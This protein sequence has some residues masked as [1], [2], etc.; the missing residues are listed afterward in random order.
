MLHVN[1]NML[2]VDIIYLACKGH[3]MPSC[4]CS[5]HCTGETHKK[6]KAGEEI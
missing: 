5:Q 4:V 2:H 6:E 1:I 3:S